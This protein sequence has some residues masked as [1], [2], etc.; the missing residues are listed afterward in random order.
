MKN[1]FLSLFSTMFVVVASSS[2]ASICPSTATTN[3]DCGFLIT[4]SAAGNATVSAVTGAKAFNSALTFNDGTTDP[5]NDGS[6]IGVI[7][8]DAQA[9]TGFTLQ[10]TGANAGIFDFSY[11]GICVYTSAA[12]CPTAQSGY[13]GPTTTFT[14]LQSSILFENNIGTVSFG[15]S[16]GTGNSTFFSVQ[17]APSDI[18]SNGGLK[19]SGLTF[20]SAVTATPEPAN[21]LLVASGISFLL[22]SRK[23][24]SR[25]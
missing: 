9:L 5:G 8:N 6:L 21:L 12:Y 7:N 4:I 15:P 24:Y 18:S 20:A 25:V 2:A 14:N 22:I 23:L 11:N 3:S 10:G 17:D 13:E 1:I 19:V 16:L